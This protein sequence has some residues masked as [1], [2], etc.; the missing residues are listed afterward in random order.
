LDGR[1]GIGSNTHATI[2]ISSDF[3]QSSRLPSEAPFPL[4]FLD[5]IRM[6]PR[7][8]S[9]LATAGEPGLADLP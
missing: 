8:E 2:C 6:N 7:V 3:Q 4:I 9:I 5:L 1:Y